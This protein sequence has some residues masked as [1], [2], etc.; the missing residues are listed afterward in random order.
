M[1]RMNS[2][3]PP[4]LVAGMLY[5]RAGLGPLTGRPPE[6]PLARL[7]EA[8]RV[9]RPMVRSALEDE[10]LRALRIASAGPPSR[11]TVDA[12]FKAGTDAPGWEQAVR[13]G[14]LSAGQLAS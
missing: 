4:D 8:A 10:D 1:W 2:R 14:K 6:F 9:D 3:L 7:L 12:L 11:D 13:D 5:N